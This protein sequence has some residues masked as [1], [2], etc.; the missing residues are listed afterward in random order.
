MH[1]LTISWFS[2]LESNAFVWL[3]NTWCTQ[4]TT[5]S[6]SCTTCRHYKFCWFFHSSSFNLISFR[7]VHIHFVWILDAC[8]FLFMYRLFIFFTD[9][10]NQL[11]TLQ[12]Y[13][14]GGRLITWLE[15]NLIIN[16]THC[17]FMPQVAQACHWDARGTRTVLFVSC[18]R[19][20]RL[21]AWLRA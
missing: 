7:A 20:V 6:I 16:W 11:S 19:H 18:Y 12:I 3:D 14:T 21:P 8:S 17:R 10:H 2:L 9:F 15:H 4:A 13:A 1:M 5:I